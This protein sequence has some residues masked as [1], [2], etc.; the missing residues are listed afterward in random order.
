MRL[1]QHREVFKLDVYAR[2]DCPLEI[3]GVFAKTQQAKWLRRS[4]NIRHL[5][6]KGLMYAWRAEETGGVR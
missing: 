6:Y 1:R 4:A 2:P 5:A 3:Q